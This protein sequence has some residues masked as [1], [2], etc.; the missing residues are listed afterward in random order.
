MQTITGFGKGDLAP[1]SGSKL[2]SLRSG[3]SP[4]RYTLKAQEEFAAH[5]YNAA[6][7]CAAARQSILAS[8][9][10]GADRPRDRED[11]GRITFGRGVTLTSAT[12]TE[13]DETFRRHDRRGQ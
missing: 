4:L 7:T 1:L 13:S 10:L 12:Q 8:R 6:I 11:D 9:A 2:K 5:G 3:A